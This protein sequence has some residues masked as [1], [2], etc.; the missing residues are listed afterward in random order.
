MTGKTV[1]ITGATSG[2]GAHTARLLL[3]RGHRVAVTGRDETKLKSFLD[4]TGH[5]DHPRT[6]ADGDPELWAPMVL[7][8]PRLPDQH[9]RRSQAGSRHD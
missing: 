1:L 7:V 5:P 6:I 8:H 4:E 2:I 3:E 9:R